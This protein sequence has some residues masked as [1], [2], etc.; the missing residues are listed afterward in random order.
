[1]KIPLK[2]VYLFAEPE[3]KMQTACEPL[4][5]RK[6]QMLQLD[7]KRRRQLVLYIRPFAF[8]NFLNEHLHFVC[9]GHLHS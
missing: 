3:G 1:M 6:I 9:Q 4:T 8:G 2:F 7:I 5:N